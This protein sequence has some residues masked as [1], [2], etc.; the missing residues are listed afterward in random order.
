MKAAKFEDLLGKTIHRVKKECGDDTRDDELYFFM[1]DGSYYR[2][3][4]ERDCCEEVYIED[5][6]GEIDWLIDYPILRAEERSNQEGDQSG[7]SC[8]WT[9][10]ELATLQGAVTIRWYGESN[11]YY[12]E[13]VSFEKVK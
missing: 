1:S 4:H 8:T 2:M 12:S 6:C 11:G 3:Y 13:R 7:G 5:I 10:Y 9:F